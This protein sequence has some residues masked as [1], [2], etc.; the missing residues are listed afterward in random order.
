LRKQTLKEFHDS[1]IQGSHL[2][3]LKTIEKMKSRIFWPSMTTDIK[4]YIRTCEICQKGKI[5]PG[6]RIPEPLHPIKIPE[7]PFDRIHIDICG[8]LN[9][10]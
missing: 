3:Q 6:D 5:N 4:E 8:P 2:G 10:T 9:Q 7:F 1:P